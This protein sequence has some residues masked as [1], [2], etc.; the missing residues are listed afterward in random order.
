MSKG[1]PH[2]GKA[3]YPI[4][5]DDGTANWKN[6]LRIDWMAV[7]LTI[8]FIL[9]FVG[10]KE[11]NEQCYNYVNHSCDVFKEFC[12]FNQTIEE[13]YKLDISK[14]EVDDSVFKKGENISERVPS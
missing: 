1:C 2:C 3:P 8:T 4:K 9:L 7:A 11:V 14:F 6:I 13:K 10:V 12:T 5:N